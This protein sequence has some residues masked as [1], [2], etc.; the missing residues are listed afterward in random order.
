MFLIRLD[1][2][3]WNRGVE[4][5][6]LAKGLMINLEMINIEYA[7]PINSFVQGIILAL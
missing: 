4:N 7:L 1:R 5:E 2:E 3:K 6:V